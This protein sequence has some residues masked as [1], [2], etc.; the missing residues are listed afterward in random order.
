MN[1]PILFVDALRPFATALLTGDD[2]GPYPVR[3]VGFPSF[4]G[5]FVYR[6]WGKAGRC[7]YVGLTG[8]TAP[9]LLGARM[10]EHAKDKWWWHQVCRIDALETELPYLHRLEAEE[11]RHHRPLYNRKKEEW[12]LDPSWERAID[13]RVARRPLCMRAAPEHQ[14]G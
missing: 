5:H 9:R 6:I 13:Y 11:I 4:A 1:E 2:V 8:Q 14:E 7:L 3:W 12:A 10:A